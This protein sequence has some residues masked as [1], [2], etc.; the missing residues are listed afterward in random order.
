MKTVVTNIYL[1]LAKLF[2]ENGYILYM[3]GGSSRDYIMSRDT[4]DLD[5]GTDATPDQMI[6]FLRDK[7]D[8][9][10]PFKK[11]G[12][13]KIH[14]G[15]I[16]IDITT[17][18]VEGEYDDSRHPSKISFVKDPESDSK[19]RDFT[20]NAFYLKDDLKSI[21]DYHNG[22]D[23][24]V[25]NRIRMIGDPLVRIN[26]DPLRI[27]RALRFSL[28]LNFDL[29]DLLSNAIKENLFLLNLLNPEKIKEEVNK[30]L[31]I[32]PVKGEALLKSYNIL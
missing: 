29:D 16:L 24:L 20:I 9:K 3:V 28:K 8:I 21:Y 4:G 25:G 6:P 10:T 1:K 5:L 18:R 13:I 27:L 7:Y 12:N 26:E 14:L 19:R 22:V 11:Y 2:K 15:D 32:N 31:N 23:D 17:L 30:I